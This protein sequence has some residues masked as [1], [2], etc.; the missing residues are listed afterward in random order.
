[1]RPYPTFFVVHFETGGDTR[2]LKHPQ[3]FWQATIDLMDCANQFDAKLT[4]QFNPQR[5]KYI[6]KDPLKVKIV[7]RDDS[8][9]NTQLN[10]LCKR[11]MHP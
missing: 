2:N 5:A 11:R 4:L 3:A 8:I 7:R 1:M 6:L 9:K 10:S